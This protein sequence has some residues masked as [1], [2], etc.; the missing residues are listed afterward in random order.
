MAQAKTAQSPVPKPV[1]RVA[2]L[3]LDEAEAKL[4]T[5][6]FKQFNVKTTTLD[7][8]EKKRLVKE[9]FEGCVVRLDDS[10]GAVLEA[11]RNSPSNRRMLIYG[12]T[13]DTKVAMRYS[14]YCIN[15]IFP[16]PLERSAA[17]KV[18][19]ATYLL[20][21]HEYRR[22]VRIPLAVQVVLSADGHRVTT[23]SEEISS[24]GMSL[25]APELMHGKLKAQAKFILPEAQEVD[26]TA[27]IC[28]RREASSMIGIRFDSEHK[29]RQLV[30]KWIDDFLQF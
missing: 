27:T 15:A 20:A 3:D 28:W 2:L 23:L 1:T 22:Y 26:I 18:V 29:S 17:L 8:D 12:I 13:S 19:R 14:K 16:Y 11:A 25:R 24:G 10:A 21:L 5:D 4:L 9:K 7:G 30:Q 6:C